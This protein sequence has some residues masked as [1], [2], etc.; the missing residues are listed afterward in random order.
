MH[1]TLSFTE[2]DGL[3]QVAINHSN[4]ETFPFSL[5]RETANRG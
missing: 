1:A 3:S 2:A 5:R 4:L